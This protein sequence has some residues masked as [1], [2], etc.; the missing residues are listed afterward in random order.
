[1]LQVHYTT[2]PVSYS[3]NSPIVSLRGTSLQEER[4]EWAPRHGRHYFEI[5]ADDK[6]V[7]QIDND[8]KDG[9]YKPNCSGSFTKLK[10]GYLGTFRNGNEKTW[11]PPAPGYFYF[12]VNSI[13]ICGQRI[14]SVAVDN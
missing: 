13:S 8:P 9:D 7:Y 12:Y 5:Y 2:T 10:V 4:S 14:T 1:V 6:L 11:D 3:V